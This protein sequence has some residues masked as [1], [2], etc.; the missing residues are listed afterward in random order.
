MFTNLR[1]VCVNHYCACHNAACHC[2]KR[3]LLTYLL[4]YLLTCREAIFPALNMPKLAAEG[5]G[6]RVCNG[7]NEWKIFRVRIGLT[8]N[9][10]SYVLSRA[11]FAQE[12]SDL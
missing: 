2:L 10:D 11:S 3:I 8:H 5:G 4:T 6:R 12:G 1:L 9:L 7:R